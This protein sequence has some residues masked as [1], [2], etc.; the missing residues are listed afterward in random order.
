MVSGPN[1]VGGRI[2]LPALTP[3]DIQTSA[4][5]FASGELPAEREARSRWER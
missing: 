2:D 1:Q 3:P 4:G 5:A